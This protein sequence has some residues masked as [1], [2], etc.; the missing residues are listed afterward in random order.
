MR[1][2]EKQTISNLL[3]SHTQFVIPDYQRG[4]DW[5]ADT[6]LKDLFLDLT[7][8]MNEG[9]SSQLFLGTMLF[10]HS[11]DRTTPNKDTV[12]IID[13]QQRLT[14]ILILLVACRQYA[15]DVL[16]SGTLVTACQ[17]KIDAGDDIVINPEP[18]LVASE[19]IRLVFH[20]ICKQDWDGT[21]PDKIDGVGAVFPNRRIKPIYDACLKEIRQFSGEGSEDQFRKFLKQI[22]NDT[23]V[24]TIGIDDQ[25]EAF[26]IFERTN[27]RGK[28]LAVEDLL[29][30]FLFSKDASAEASTRETW[31]KISDNAGTSMLRMLKYFWNS[32]GGSTSTKKL[33]RNLKEYHSKTTTDE[34]ITELLDFSKFYKAYQDKESVAL[35]HWLKKNADIRDSMYLSEMVRAINA[36]KLFKVTQ[37]TP[38]VYSTIISL[39]RSGA[40]SKSTKKVISFFRLL[41]S[42]HYVNNKVCNRVGNE[43]EKLY[44]LYSQKFF[45]ADNPTK[46]ITELSGKLIEKMANQ[47]EFEAAFKNLTYIQ[48]SDRPII[49]YTIDKIVNVGVKPG[50]RKNLIDLDDLFNGVKPDHDIEHIYPQASAEIVEEWLHEVGNLTVIPRQINGILGSKSAFEKAKILLNPQDFD[51]NIKHVDDYLREVAQEIISS[52]AWDKPEVQARTKALATR[53]YNSAVSGY[54]Y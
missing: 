15:K 36:L 3:G 21:F 44:Q 17:K 20:N 34:F 4:Y 28:E 30:N 37:A 18:K 1:A 11:Q 27:A 9:G 23:V 51:N 19:S 33:Y 43:V 50:Q 12:D 29:K 39:S 42:Y 45:K 41:E 35:K 16:D 13:G 2:P 48:P 31:E 47:E 14:T 54:K 26:E 53:A 22:L 24:I 25:S 7:G 38:L 10:D 52:D 46:L 49:K 6:Q 5:K 32:R 40:D 8:A